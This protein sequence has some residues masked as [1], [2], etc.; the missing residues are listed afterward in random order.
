M[1]IV[2]SLLNILV[3]GSDDI[4]QFLSKTEIDQIAAMAKA[5]PDELA[6]YMDDLPAGLANNDVFMGVMRKIGDNLDQLDSLESGFRAGTVSGDDIVK[7]MD[8]DVSGP[9]AQQIGKMDDAMRASMAE[10][11]RLLAEA[12]NSRSALENFQAGV[13]NPPAPTTA[14]DLAAE[15]GTN[16]Q[17]RGA[18]GEYIGP[19]TGMVPKKETPG[20]E[21]PVIEGEF[22]NVTSGTGMTARQ[23]TDMAPRQGGDAI[24]GEWLGPVQSTAGNG[25]ELGGRTFDGAFTRVD[26]APPPR[27]NYVEALPE[28]EVKT[29]LTDMERA[30]LQRGI[31]ADSAAYRAD[32]QKAA[33]D[34]AAARSNADNVDQPKSSKGG[35][36]DGSSGGGK[37]KDADG[38]APK[39][40]W[41]RNV[42]LATGALMIGG[43]ILGGD[44]D[45]NFDGKTVIGGKEVT[46]SDIP[47]H[48]MTNE[49]FAEHVAMNPDQA[50]A[51]N[52]ARIKAL[53]DN[54]YGTL[55]ANGQFQFD[56]NKWNAAR[57]AYVQSIKGG[58]TPQTDPNAPESGGNTVTRWGDMFRDFLKQIQDLLQNIM[59]QIGAGGGLFGNLDKRR[60]GRQP[61]ITDEGGEP[62]QLRPQPT[63]QPPGP[64]LS[65]A[66]QAENDLLKEHH[67]YSKNTI[68][69]I[70]SGQMSFDAMNAAGIQW[71]DHEI[72]TENAD[73]ER[74]LNDNIQAGF[75]G[76][77]GGV[78]HIDEDASLV[79][80][81]KDA[82]GDVVGYKLND[83]INDIPNIND[84]PYSQYSLSGFANTMLINDRHTPTYEDRTGLIKT[85]EFEEPGWEIFSGG[86]VDNNQLQFHV[87]IDANGRQSINV[88]T[89]QYK[90]DHHSTLQAANQQ[91]QK[92]VAD[93]DPGFDSYVQGTDHIAERLYKDIDQNRSPGVVSETV[94]AIT[95]SI[96]IHGVLLGNDGPKVIM[97]NKAHP[98]H[99][100]LDDRGQIQNDFKRDNVA[101]EM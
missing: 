27:D 67:D 84:L 24:E 33:D 41:K 87:T 99:I 13:N 83:H 44:G 47:L 92:E 64:Q 15:T 73:Y 53:V 71:E 74:I 55:D 68:E 72:I 78:L 51:L 36:G 10:T 65:P 16:M 96:Q 6:K 2:Q 4:A 35:D 25:G 101:I 85:I 18:Q 42:M 43:M 69:G 28:K 30:H 5:G 19:E 1:A 37:G 89:D 70:T 59:R 77:T 46:I 7:A 61:D 49:E 45:Q 76:G 82:N 8:I 29:S 48:L 12:A 38:D 22:T 20:I 54:G 50:E 100:R 32:R 60:G 39:S 90:Q 86:E 57:E 31:D 56:Q 14:T 97:S 88:I 62:T 23:S 95:G 79:Y 63:P 11:D 58:A 17:P 21:S 34:L 80:L 81:T 94:R 66:Q 40:K 75:D 98:D 3:D 93:V 9:L 52:E 91:T 26:D